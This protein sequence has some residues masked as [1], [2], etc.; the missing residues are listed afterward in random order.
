M[1]EK[2]NPL[3][4]TPI[5]PMSRIRRDIQSMHAYAVPAITPEDF[6]ALQIL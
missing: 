4:P 5:T 1:T 2:L 6:L 3:I